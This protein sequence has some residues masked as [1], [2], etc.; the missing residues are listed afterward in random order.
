[1]F[2][3]S[4]CR[5]FSVQQTEGMRKLNLAGVALHHRDNSN[6]RCHQLLSLGS[7]DLDNIAFKKPEQINITLSSITTGSEASCNIFFW[8]LCL[9]LNQLT[10]GNI[11][12]ATYNPISRYQFLKRLPLPD[13]FSIVVE[14]LEL[15]FTDDDPLIQNGELS[16]HSRSGEFK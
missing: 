1:M 6:K 3:V 12:W 8:L 16:S 2:E 10:G 4:Y 14:L 5:E 9:L 15:V 11:Y 7:K 13:T